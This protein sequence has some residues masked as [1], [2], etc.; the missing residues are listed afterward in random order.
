MK[1]GGTT[2]GIEF[3]GGSSSLIGADKIVKA[4]LPIGG[5][6]CE[7]PLANAVGITR[8]SKICG[9]DDANAG[10]RFTTEANGFRS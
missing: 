5:T 1:R 8:S 10:G 4:R 7:G 6:A 9:D 3:L 2:A